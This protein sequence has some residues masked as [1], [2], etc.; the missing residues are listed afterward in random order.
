MWVN[1]ESVIT[2]KKGALLGMEIVSEKC[3]EELGKCKAHNKMEIVQSRMD[4]VKKY[5]CSPSGIINV[6]KKI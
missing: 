5:C 1:E 2:M 6:Y 3:L 4:L